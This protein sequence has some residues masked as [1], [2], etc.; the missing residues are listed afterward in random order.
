MRII[1]GE[2]SGRRIA[3]PHG[4]GTRPML[5]RVREAMFST[6][7]PW[8]DGAR[9]LDLF[10]G[11]GSLGFEALSRGAAHA[12]LVEQG[13]GVIPLLEENVAE[14]ALE[15]RTMIVRGDALAAR[16]WGETARFDIVFL[17]PPYPMVREAGT[18]R[19][20]FLALAELVQEH[21]APE[22]IVVLHTPKRCIG[23]GDFPAGLRTAE[24]KYGTNVLWYVQ[25]P[26]EG[27]D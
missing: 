10:A 8:L 27:D 1:G 22:G 5:D 21:L 2:L 20:V 7:A 15:A 13:I 25:G 3:A 23:R 14:L 16:S 9:V 12:T 24:R 4:R 6:L 19:V 26:E 18:R 11:T 17:D